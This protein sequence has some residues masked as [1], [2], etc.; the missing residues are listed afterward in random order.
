MEF[1][2]NLNN[3][4]HLVTTKYAISH[5]FEYTWWSLFY[6]RFVRTKYDIYVIIASLVLTW[7]L[8]AKSWHAY[9]D[10][11]YV[12]LYS[13]LQLMDTKLLHIANSGWKYSISFRIVPTVFSKYPGCQFYGIWHHSNW[14]QSLICLMSSTH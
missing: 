7:T 8:N 5:S 4:Y 11:I 12:W 10:F 9:T 1:W 3:N 6:K 2:L 13:L 14:E